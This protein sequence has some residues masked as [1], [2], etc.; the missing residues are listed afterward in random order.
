M[1]IIEALAK[2]HEAMKRAL[3]LAERNK[4][5]EKE[6]KDIDHLALAVEAECNNTVKT[7]TEKVNR[8]LIFFSCFVKHLFKVYRTGCKKVFFKFKL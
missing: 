3:H 2:Q 7:N 8:Y 6:M 4:M 1:K 5:L